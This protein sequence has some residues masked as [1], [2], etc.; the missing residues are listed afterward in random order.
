MSFQNNSIKKECIKQRNYKYFGFKHFRHL[1]AW[2]QSA[3]GKINLTLNE[4]IKIRLKKTNWPKH[5]GYFI[6][7]LR[8][9]RSQQDLTTLKFIDGKFKD[10][11]NS[12]TCL[13]Q[14]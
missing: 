7:G 4:E 12:K 2:R 8:S 1:N 10:R 14:K 11:T 3:F 9:W 6:E 13:N 5:F